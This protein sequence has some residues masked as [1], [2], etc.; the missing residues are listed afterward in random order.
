MQRGRLAGGLCHVVIVEP[1]DRPSDEHELRDE[2]EHGGRKRG[3]S[4]GESRP[5]DSISALRY[6]Q[7]RDSDALETAC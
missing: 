6:E 5:A 1:R 3:G 7:A 4:A 2:R